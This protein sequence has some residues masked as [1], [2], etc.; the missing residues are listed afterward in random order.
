MFAVIKTGGKQYKVSKDDVLSVE[1]LTAEVGSTIEVGSVLMIGE[2]GKA[3]TLGAPIVNE[4]AVFG[5]VVDQARG[6]KVIIFKKN[7]RHGYR[8]TKGHRQDITLLQ[9][10]EISPKGGKPATEKVNSESKPSGAPKAE[11]AKKTKAEKPAAT[12]SAATDSKE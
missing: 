6:R 9:I 3:P 7:R 5:K 12:D 2:E 11:S 4:A 10:T 8:R 1:K